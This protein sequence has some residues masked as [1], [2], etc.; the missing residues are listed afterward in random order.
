MPLVQ[1]NGGVGPMRRAL[2]LRTR[3]VLA[4]GSRSMLMRALLALVV[5]CVAIVIAC[6]DDDTA[7]DV[8]PEL[9][10]QQ[11]QQAAVTVEQEQERSTERRDAAPTAAA[12]TAQEI[13]DQRDASPHRTGRFRAV[14]TGR[15]QVRRHCRLP[16]HSR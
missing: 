16:I 11:E 8:A 13:A 2:S 3:T 10:E 14:R 6:S 1:V 4:E 7:T 12:E 9:Q 15:D 5:G